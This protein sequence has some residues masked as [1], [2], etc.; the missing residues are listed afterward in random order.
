MAAQDE[1]LTAIF[2]AI[3]KTVKDLEADGYPAS[4]RAEALESLALAYRYAR[5]GAQPGASV[6]PS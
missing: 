1:A 3:T 5:G 2:T 4:A 6:I